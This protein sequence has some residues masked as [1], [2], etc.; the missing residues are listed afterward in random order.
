MNPRLRSA[1]RYLRGIAGA[2]LRFTAIVSG[3]VTLFLI[4]APVVGYLPYSDRPGPGWFGSF[5]AISPSQFFENSLS[6]LSTGLFLALLLLLPAL[7]CTLTVRLIEA[8][9]RRPP[10][11][12]VVGGLCGGVLGGYWMTGA[13]WYI[14]AGEALFWLALVLGVGAGVGAVPRRTHGRPA[15]V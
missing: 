4:F 5:P 3:G 8:L 10:I 1:L 13:G 9:L 6:M 11:A 12:Q 14:S 7:V 2:T 15:A